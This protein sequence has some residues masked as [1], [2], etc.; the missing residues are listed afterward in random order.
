MCHEGSRLWST[1]VLPNN[2]VW[3]QLGHGNK[4]GETTAAVLVAARR[5]NL[6]QLT[7]MHLLAA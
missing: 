6:Q 4:V 7:C 2:N 1:A 5:S 3:Q